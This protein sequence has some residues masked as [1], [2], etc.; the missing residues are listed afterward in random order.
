MSGPAQVINHIG[1]L[2]NMVNIFLRASLPFS[3]FSITFTT[4]LSLAIPTSCEIRYVNSF[5]LGRGAET[6]E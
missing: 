2:R 4:N 1:V 3:R 6:S 5:Q